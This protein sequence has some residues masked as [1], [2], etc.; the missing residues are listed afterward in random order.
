MRTSRHTPP[1]DAAVLAL[2][3]A[4]VC[5]P[6]AAGT[7]H[8]ALDGAEPAVL[9]SVALVGATL[10]GAARALEDAGPAR[11][12]T[13]TAAGV[14]AGN[15]AH[16]DLYGLSG[17]PL[18]EVRP[19]AASEGPGGVVLTLVVD[20]GPAVRFGDV[21]A[22][23][24]AVTRPRVIARASGIEPG[25]PY[26]AAR[27]AEVR[28]RL[29]RLGFFA[30]VS[31][32]VVAFDEE[33]GL[34]LVGVEIEE[35]AVS[36][37]AGVL[38]YDASGDEGAVTGFVDVAVGNIAGTGRSAAASWR[39]LGAGSSGVSFS[40]TEP[41]VLGSAIDVSVSGAQAVRDTLYTVT[42]GDLL[43]TARMADRTA[44]T[45]TVGGERYAPGG[46]AGTGVTTSARTSLGA[47]FDGSDAPA[48]PTRGLRLSG[49]A[50]YAAKEERG[51]GRKERAGVFT[52][53]AEA[54]VP[55]RMRQ[56][57]ALAAR[58]AAISSTEDDVPEHELLVLGGARSLRGYREEQ[59]RGTRTAL[60]TVEY[61]FILARRSR[62]LAFLDAGYCH[63]G[64]PNFAK[65][66]KLG[67]GIGLRVDTRLGIMSLDYGLGEGDRP[68]DGKLHVGLSREF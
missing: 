18:A 21:V 52:V 2:A 16:L 51:T 53:D 4:A 35:A 13:L 7:A 58:L 57:V 11:G 61:R 34:A 26:D 15:E 19:A 39:R 36:R 42:E 17:R 1:R 37:V 55:V 47:A 68:L 63:R 27:V 44:V 49:R 5:L 20:E 14:E 59:F 54:F 66:T 65:D 64:G 9:D 22:R 46:S 43:V 23:G 12:D 31:D 10:P 8:A 3:A 33:A 60:G 6:F 56:V 25:A 40:Y 45:W 24:N 30:S 41:W 62:A 28:G 29:E 48:N 32:P 50:E 67:Y 38:G